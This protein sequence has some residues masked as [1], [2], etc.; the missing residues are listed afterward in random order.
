MKVR[1][2]SPSDRAA[3]QCLAPAYCYS[4]PYLLS[5]IYYLPS[6]PDTSYQRSSSLTIEPMI[7]DL[8]WWV[9]ECN[10]RDLKRSKASLL[11]NA[12]HHRQMPLAGPCTCSRPRRSPMGGLNHTSLELA[13]PVPSPC[14][15]PSSSSSSLSSSAYKVLE[16]STCNF[17]KFDSN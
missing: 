3:G 2:C 1:P 5:T 17:L 11:L 12:T 8:L 9:V 7:Q 6:A 15:L 14:H 10:Q 16:E 4:C 13:A